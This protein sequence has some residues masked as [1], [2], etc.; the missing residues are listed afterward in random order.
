MIFLSAGTDEL[1]MQFI[2]YRHERRHLFT[3]K[4]NTSRYGWQ[5][6]ILFYFIFFSEKNPQI[7]TRIIIIIKINLKLNVQKVQKVNYLYILKNVFADT[8][9]EIWDWQLM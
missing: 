9:Y 4:R 7:L 5:Y 2:L 8:F 1:T 6:I 3:K